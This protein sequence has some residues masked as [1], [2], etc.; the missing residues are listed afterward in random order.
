MSAANPAPK[1][2]DYQ[3]PEYPAE[4]RAVGASGVVGLRVTVNEV[5]LVAEARR[6]G[7]TLSFTD[8]AVVFTSGFIPDAFEALANKAV[9][10]DKDGRVADNRALL[11][12]ADAMTQA[13]LSAVRNWRYEAPT[14][15]PVTFDVRVHFKTDGETSATVGSETPAVR[16]GRSRRLLAKIDPGDG[17]VRVGGNI[18]PPTKIHDVRPVYPPAAQQARVSGMVIVEARIGNDGSVET[19]QVLRSIP[20]LD[21]AAMDAVRQ[22]KFTPTLL[23]GVPVAGHHDDDGELHAAVTG[24]LNRIRIAWV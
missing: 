19:V 18:K 1:R 6:T 10:R 5:G 20:L 17:A 8:P 11:R 4:A 7:F 12:V 16:G 2:T 14:N 9:I 3:A 13:A 21:E 22:W 23:N 15:G 24:S